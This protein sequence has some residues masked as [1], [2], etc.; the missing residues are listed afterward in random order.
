MTITEAAQKWGY[1]ANWV[2]ELVKTGRIKATFRTDMP[3]PFWDIPE[4]ER[5]QRTSSALSGTI[6]PPEASKKRKVAEQPADGA[7]E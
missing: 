2:R 5:P 6:R 4:Q 1:S 3:V 7:D